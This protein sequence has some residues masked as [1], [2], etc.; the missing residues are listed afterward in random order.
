M[1]QE[2]KL[3]VNAKNAID[4]LRIQKALNK[5]TQKLND[6][7]QVERLASLADSEKAVKYLSSDIQ[8]GVLKTFL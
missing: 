4:A 3:Q 8:F 1:P 2:I 5:I 6:P 7:K